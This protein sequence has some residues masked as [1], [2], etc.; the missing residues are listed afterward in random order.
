M[1]SV[2]NALN[3][4]EYTIDEY[5]REPNIQMFSC[6]GKREILIKVRSDFTRLLQETTTILEDQVKP[7]FREGSSSQRMPSDDTTTT[8][9]P[10]VGVDDEDNVSESAKDSDESDCE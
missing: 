4:L 2:Q 3:A 9:A 5:R 7:Y 6:V 1:S 8:A 10:D